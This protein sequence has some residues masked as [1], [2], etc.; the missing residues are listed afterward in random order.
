MPK[1]AHHRGFGR[2]LCNASIRLR[3]TTDQF[4]T[5]REFMLDL[6]GFYAPLQL[7][8]PAESFMLQCSSQDQI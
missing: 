5:I 7:Q 8:I 2:T 4:S 6:Q 1:T 3:D